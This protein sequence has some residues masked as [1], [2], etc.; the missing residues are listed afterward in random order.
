MIV[1]VTRS[2]GMNTV[3]VPADAGAAP[4]PA[5][6]RGQNMTMFAGDG[7]DEAADQ[8][9]LEEHEKERGDVWKHIKQ[10]RRKS[11]N[12]GVCKNST[13]QGLTECPDG[14]EGGT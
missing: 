8:A 7:E 10:M 13:V 4:P 11:T 5:S 3:T 6:A 14:D 12:I 2:M 1:D 9:R